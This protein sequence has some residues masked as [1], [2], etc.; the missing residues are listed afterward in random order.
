V[1][2]GALGREKVT[3]KQSRLFNPT[4]L[5]HSTSAKESLFFTV[6]F[7]FRKILAVKPRNSA[8]RVANRKW[9]QYLVSTMLR[10]AMKR[11]Q[12]RFLELEISCSI[13]LSYGRRMH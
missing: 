11:P 10:N 7:T 4:A 2:T 3:E 5:D 12:T 9:L 13:G 6:V 8:R 1:H